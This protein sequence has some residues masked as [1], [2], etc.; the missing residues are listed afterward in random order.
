[1]LGFFDV[2]LPRNDKAKKLTKPVRTGLD[3]VGMFDAADVDH[4]GGLNETE[5]A[6]NEL[7][8][9]HFATIDRDG[10]GLLQIGEILAAVKATA[11]KR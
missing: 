10:D 6:G 5:A 4:N 9:E 3:I 11:K 7:L 8:K 1:M 2:I